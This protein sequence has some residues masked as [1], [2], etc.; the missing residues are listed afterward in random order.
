MPLASIASMPAPASRR[1]ISSASGGSMPHDRRSCH[2]PG[3]PRVPVR[4]E[5][6]V[7]R[8]ADRA[9]GGAA[10]RHARAAP[11]LLYGVS[12]HE[13]FPRIVQRRGR[14]LLD[15]LWLDLDPDALARRR[16]ALCRAL[17]RRRALLRAL[18]APDL[19]G[20]FRPGLRPRLQD[21]DRVLGDGPRRPLCRLRSSPR[22]ARLGRQ[23]AFAPFGRS[24][25]DT[26]SNR[27]SLP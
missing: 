26:L 14:R 22:L 16:A 17:A 3:L 18:P 24:R 15:A 7:G 9:C 1:A 5:R 27:S 11:P 12:A 23:N 25:C 19:R 4:P 8:P 20:H 2:A 10:R 21:A 13:P 6:A